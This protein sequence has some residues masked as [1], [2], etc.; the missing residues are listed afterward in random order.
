[1]K[2]SP[3]KN[4][5]TAT[6]RVLGK[7]YMTTGETPYEAIEKLNPGVARGVSILN[8]NGKERIIPATQ[9]LRLF[10]T[11]G[12]SRE[13]MLKNIALTFDGV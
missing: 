11:R 9:T 5:Y 10:N 2:K 3:K 7:N 8:V 12:V 1:M 6:L 4:T 13:V